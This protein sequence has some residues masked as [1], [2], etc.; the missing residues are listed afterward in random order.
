MLVMN[1]ALA[2]PRFSPMQTFAD[3]VRTHRAALNMKQNT[4]AAKAG[5]SQA[6]VSGI[7]R[8]INVDVDPVIVRNLA[9]ALQQSPLEAM[10]I[11]YPAGVPEPPE[12][13]REFDP[14]C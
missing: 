13:V 10:R 5:I 3:Y 7:E 14:P 9:V 12:I 11:V 2:A 1:R 6:Y 4:L 8:G